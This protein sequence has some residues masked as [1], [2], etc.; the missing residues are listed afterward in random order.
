MELKCIMSPFIYLFLLSTL[1]N[2]TQCVHCTCL[3]GLCARLC[4]KQNQVHSDPSPTTEFNNC[5]QFDSPANQ[6]NTSI[7]SPKG[8][9]LFEMPA[10]TLQHQA[11]STPKGT[12]N[13]ESRSGVGS[14]SWWTPR[15]GSSKPN[16]LS[17]NIDWFDVDTDFIAN[18]NA[19]EAIKANR[20]F[21]LVTVITYDIVHYLFFIGHYLPLY[22]FP[23]ARKFR[24]VFDYFAQFQNGARR[25]DLRTEMKGFEQ[26]RNELLNL[27]HLWDEMKD[28]EQLNR[29]LGYDNNSIVSSRQEKHK[30]SSRSRGSKSSTQFWE[31]N[32]LNWCKKPLQFI[33]VHQTETANMVRMVLS[34]IS[35]E[36]DKLHKII[37]GHDEHSSGI[38]GPRS[39]LKL[40]K[41]ISHMNNNFFRTSPQVEIKL[42]GSTRFVS[43]FWRSPDKKRKMLMTLRQTMMTSL[44]KYMISVLSLARRKVAHMTLF[45][46]L[47]VE[48]D[49]S[50]A[51]WLIYRMRLDSELLGGAWRW[52]DH[53]KA[54]NWYMTILLADD[55]SENMRFSMIQDNG[56]ALF[57]LNV[58][59]QFSLVGG[60]CGYTHNQENK[61][62]KDSIV[63]VVPS[64]DIDIY[65]HN[66]QRNQHVRIPRAVADTNETQTDWEFFN[67]HTGL[68]LKNF[69][70]IDAMSVDD[71]LSITSP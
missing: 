54:T 26:I 37:T 67:D 43:L 42:K 5:L 30:R 19:S 55:G 1:I 6:E 68:K 11:L 25:V 69:T 63:C 59:L 50:G 41:A 15:S 17:A 56:G 22:H 32:W 16:T 45:L 12:I 71:S 3:A 27:G 39:L 4:G 36:M 44:A 47:D 29:L 53:L 18:N 60:R 7:L 8:Q 61:D 52:E 24:H 10:L 70:E 33:G 34:V 64:S 9:M 62:Y 57:L 35:L 20:Y 66:A 58:L 28:I 13:T 14:S 51:Q 49:M 21:L 40:G 31:T 46:E 23:N 2:S 48:K 65:G 38:T